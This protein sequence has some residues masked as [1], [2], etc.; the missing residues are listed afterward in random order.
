MFPAEKDL[1]GKVDLPAAGMNLA[2][3]PKEADY[4]AA[5]VTAKDGNIRLEGRKMMSRSPNSEKKAVKTSNLDAKE[6]KNSGAAPSVGNNQN[7]LR[8]KLTTKSTLRPPV[9]AKMAGF[10][11]FSLDYHVPQSHPP[12]NN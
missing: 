9:K 2:K 5:S 11:A 12:R 1:D 6:A 7:I 8:S 10:T 3:I 4:L